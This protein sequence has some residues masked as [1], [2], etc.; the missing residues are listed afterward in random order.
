MDRPFQEI[1]NLRLPTE[2]VALLSE[3]LISR[4]QQAVKNVPLPDARDDFGMGEAEA[5]EYAEMAAEVHAG[6]ESV[7]AASD[8]E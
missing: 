1:D 7:S 5:A 2:K 8:V 6:R 4:M 3:S